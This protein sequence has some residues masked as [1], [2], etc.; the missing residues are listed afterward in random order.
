MEFI[1]VVIYG[2]SACGFCLRAKKLAERYGMEYEYK[3]IDFEQYRTE[4]YGLKPDAETVPQ[5]WWNDKYLGGY[6]E[7]ATEIENTRNFGQDAF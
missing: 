6:N 4:M 3:N 5:I 7:F 1:M 2:K